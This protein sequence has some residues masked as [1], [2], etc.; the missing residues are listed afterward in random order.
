MLNSVFF[1]TCTIFSYMFALSLQSKEDP[2]L[3]NEATNKTN[4]HETSN[5]Y[6]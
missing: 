2:H 3:A 5:I 6:L 4:Q 1:L